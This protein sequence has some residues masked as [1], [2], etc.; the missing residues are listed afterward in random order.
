MRS[1]T[2]DTPCPVRDTEA[3]LRLLAA[4][5]RMKPGRSKPYS[6][7]AAHSTANHTFRRLLGRISPRE[8]F[9]FLKKGGLAFGL[10]TMAVLGSGCTKGGHFVAGAVST[11]IAPGDAITVILNHPPPEREW[12]MWSPSF[13]QVEY[14]E[15]LEEDM[16]EC[17]E[18]ALED[19]HPPVRIV[20]SDK[21]REAV[22]P[23]LTSEEI[24]SSD[25]SWTVLAGDRGFRKRIAPLALRYLIEVSVWKEVVAKDFQLY[26]LGGVYVRGENRSDI[27]ATVVDLL[28]ARVAGHVNATATG[29]VAAIGWIIPI[30]PV[31]VALPEGRVCDELG[32]GI[33]EILAGEPLFKEMVP[34]EF[35]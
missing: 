6:P 19:V 32:E 24:R 10:L 5:K 3:P 8:G 21:F 34:L 9:F 26:G 16:V 33:T 17:I 35:D 28:Q 11:G 18:D 27:Q 2:L 22:F 4:I 12:S 29:S 25:L 14:S 31:W 30:V 15:G 13:A 23:D 1:C 20:P 7:P